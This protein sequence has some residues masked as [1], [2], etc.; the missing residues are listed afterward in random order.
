MIFSLLIV[1]DDEDIR[2]ILKSVLSTV[3][4]L[5]LSEATDLREARRVLSKEKFDG[6]VL[7]HR[8]PDGNG[9]ELLQEINRGDFSQQPALVMHTARD[10]ELLHKTWLAM[11]ALAILKKPFS[12][13]EF[14]DQLRAQFGF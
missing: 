7:D 12:P 8:L 3:E 14:V 6:I 2:L 5:Q 1:D 9:E 10:D 13:L 11:G 4:S